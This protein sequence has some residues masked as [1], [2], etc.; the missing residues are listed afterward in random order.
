MRIYAVRLRLPV[1]ANGETDRSLRVAGM[2][3][4][5]GCGLFGCVG[6]EADSDGLVVA[7]LCSVDD[8]C[9]H[10]AV[11]GGGSA[12]QG[13]RAGTAFA[14]RTAKAAKYRPAL[15]ISRPA[16]IGTRMA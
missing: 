8:V 3:G 15:T 16:R 4:G 5:I 11:G 2:A 9:Q 13:L 6:A 14:V 7:A 1:T 12:A 10:R